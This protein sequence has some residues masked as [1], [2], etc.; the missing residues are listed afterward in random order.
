MKVTRKAGKIDAL[1]VAAKG[2]GAFEGQVGW[3]PSARYESGAPV[4]GVAAV[5]EFGS[6]S[7]GIP[8]RAPMR[9]TAESHQQQWVDTVGQIARRVAV[10]QL[11]PDAAMQAVCLQ[12]EGDARAT[13]TKLTDPPLSPRTIQARKSRLANKGRGAKAGISKPLVDTGILLNTLTS[14]VLPK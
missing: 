2:L 14:Q 13:I 3:F 12:A 1:R 9:Q 5:Q 4:A 7:R 8:P 10:G 6:A 11:P